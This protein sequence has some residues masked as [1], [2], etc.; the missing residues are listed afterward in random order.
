[1]IMT[2]KE[3]R[4]AMRTGDLE[5][6]YFDDTN[7]QA[8]S[9]DGRIGNRALIGGKDAE[10]DV[11]RS[12]SITIQPGDF[13]L[14]ITKEKLKLSNNIA[15][16]LGLKSYYGRKGLVILAGLQ[17]DPGFEGHLVIGGY[18]AAP[19]KLVLDYEAPF[20]TIEFHRLAA[21]V[22]KP[23]VSGE[24]QKRGEIPRID[25]DYLRTLETQSLSD[26]A[27]DLRKLT[28]NV[29]QMQKLLYYFYAPILF[30]IL[31]AVVGFGLK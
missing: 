5:I 22:E 14:L 10:I 3:I 28:Q 21:A 18:N 12:R 29:G 11:E 31:A 26:L 19:R 2:D 9:Y 24:E 4:D 15:G 20:V 13:V 27:S 16:N 30:L 8:A 25:K 6:E 17:I 7:L 1:M 23:Y